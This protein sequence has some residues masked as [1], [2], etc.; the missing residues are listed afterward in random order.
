MD[1]ALARMMQALQCASST[2]LDGVAPGALMFGWDMLLNIPIVTNIV[3][4]TQ[5]WQL[6]TDLQLEQQNQKQSRFNYEVG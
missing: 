1:A 3:T 2:S 5:N 6:Q 4:L